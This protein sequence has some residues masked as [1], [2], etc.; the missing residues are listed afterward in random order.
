MFDI[1]GSHLTSCYSDGINPN[2]VR[3]ELVLLPAKI[4]TDVEAAKC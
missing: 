4:T 1:C 3:S 2:L